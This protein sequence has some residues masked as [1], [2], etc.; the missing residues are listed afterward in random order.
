[1]LVRLEREIG[2]HDAEYRRNHE[3]CHRAIFLDRA[4][5]LDCH[6]IKKDFFIGFAEGGGDRVLSRIEASAGKG[7]LTCM[8]AKMLSADGEDYAWMRAVCHCDQ[9]GSG[10]ICLR[11][12]VG[13]ITFERRIGGG[14]CELI[15]KAVC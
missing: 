8:G 4:D 6:R 10:H 15:T 9:Y 1:M 14:R 5:Y 2:R 13:Q 3:A 12:F 7:N 11:S